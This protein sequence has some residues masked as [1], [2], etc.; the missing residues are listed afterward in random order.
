MERPQTLSSSCFYY[1]P[2]PDLLWVAP[3]S[4]SGVDLETRGKGAG[5]KRL[6]PT[7]CVKIEVV[8]GGREIEKQ[9]FS[10]WAKTR[11]TST[12][13]FRNVNLHMS[14]SLAFW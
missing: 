2:Y 7:V 3:Q 10:S 11:G 4:S 13:D 6:M 1:F 12:Q 9:I 5:R 8:R 14:D